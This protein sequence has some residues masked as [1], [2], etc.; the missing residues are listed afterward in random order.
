MSINIQTSAGLIPLSAKV[1]KSQVIA[2]LD[3]TPTSETIFNTHKQNTTIH[4][5]AADR[6]RWDNP[7]TDDSNHLL[8]VDSNGNIIALI[9][10]TGVHSVDFHIGADSVKQQLQ[11]LNDTTDGIFTEGADTY[12]SVQDENGNK[13]LHIDGTGMYVP[14]IYAKEIDVISARFDELFVG[15]APLA[16]IITELAQGISDIVA[17]RLD[18]HIGDITHLTQEQRDKLDTITN[19]EGNHFTLQDEEGN[20]AFQVDDD[21]AKA[22]DFQY[23]DIVTNGNSTTEEVRSLRE[24]IAGINQTTTGLAATDVETGR[25]VYTLEE[26]IKGLSGAM[27]FV[28]VKEEVPTNV[29][30][31][32]A[33]D[34]IVV[35]NK[36]WVF[37]GVEFVEFGDIDALSSRVTALENEVPDYNDLINTPELP[38]ITNAQDTALIVQDENGD[39]A[40]QFDQSGLTTTHLNV[41]SGTINGKSMAT[42]ADVEQ[43]KAEAQQAL[44]DYDKLFVAITNSEITS[45]CNSIFK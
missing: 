38:D 32:A 1:T 18:G 40:M 31:Y 11:H 2:A 33:G 22:R 43:A 19:N 9:D 45:L 3:Y 5:T 29:A 30:G 14:S 25:R 41:K 36:E 16:D 4:V 27:H 35:G 44:V 37:N 15:G 28:G 6:E 8:I 20:V 42:M 34:V 39:I 10:D 17:G 23:I 12:L 21:G 7:L 13:I 24:V 26:Q